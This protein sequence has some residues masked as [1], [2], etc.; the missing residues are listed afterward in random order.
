MQ[1]N[2]HETDNIVLSLTMLGWV[3]PGASEL[4]AFFCIVVCEGL[5]QFARANSRSRN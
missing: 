4:T 1:G 2:H 3:H 5:P